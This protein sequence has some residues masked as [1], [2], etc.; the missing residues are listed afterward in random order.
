MNRT[1]TLRDG[2]RHSLEPNGMVFMLPTLIIYTF[3]VG[4]PSIMTLGY[5]FTD[6][7]IGGHGGLYRT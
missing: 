1:G 4:L 7:R 5:A 2:S 6:W 3:V